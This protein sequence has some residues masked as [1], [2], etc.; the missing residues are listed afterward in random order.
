ME[1]PN[2]VSAE[3]GIGQSALRHAFCPIFFC[4]QLEFDA[5]FMICKW[6]K[7]RWGHFQMQMAS[8]V[9]NIQVW[10]NGCQ[11]VFLQFVILFLKETV[12]GLFVGPVSVFVSQWGCFQTF[13]AVSENHRHSAYC[14]SEWRNPYNKFFVNILGT[15]ADWLFSSNTTDAYCTKDHW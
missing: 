15:L 12:S 1:L 6:R 14:H 5:L 8:W 11:Y 4:S 9:D 2:C 3:I 13:C 10:N 7:H